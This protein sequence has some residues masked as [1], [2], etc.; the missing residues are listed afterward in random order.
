MSSET[1]VLAVTAPDVAAAVASTG[2]ALSYVM[3]PVP[4]ST[5]ELSATPCTSKPADSDTVGVILSD[6]LR[7]DPPRLDRS[8]RR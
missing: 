5:H 7:I 2:G 8:K 4:L 3:P 6:A 1:A